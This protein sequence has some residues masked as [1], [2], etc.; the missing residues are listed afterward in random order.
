MEQEKLLDIIT[1]LGAASIDIES[2]RRNGTKK[3]KHASMLGVCTD[4]TLPGEPSKAKKKE[5]IKGMRNRNSR[6][7]INRSQCSNKNKTK[8]LDEQCSFRD[9]PD[10]TFGQMLSAVFQSETVEFIR[11]YADLLARLSYLQWQQAQ[12]D[13]HLHLGQMQSVS[14]NLAPKHLAEKNSMV[15]TYGR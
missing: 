14:R 6:N 1:I 13:R 12:W 15:H 11:E 10:R 4:Q 3:Q 2:E 9:V 5:K 8:I 7:T